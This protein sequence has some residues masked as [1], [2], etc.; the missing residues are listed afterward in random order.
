MRPWVVNIGAIV[1]PKVGGAKLSDRAVMKAD[2]QL[3]GTPSVVFD[4]IAAVLSDAGADALAHEG[5]AMAFVRDAFAHLKAIAIDA[6]GQRLLQMAG[7]PAD[8]GVLPAG[9][10]AG[11]VKAAK[12]RLWKREPSVRTLA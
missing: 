3:A 7:V 6:G 5:A 2:G 8:A 12:G 1:A 10:L 11:F 4:A 9:D